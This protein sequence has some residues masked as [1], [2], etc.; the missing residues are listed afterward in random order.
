[1]SLFR[2]N[3]NR[4]D[5]G[6]VVVDFEKSMRSLTKL[7]S[8]DFPPRD[9]K[10]FL[11]GGAWRA[12]VLADVRRLSNEVLTALEC[13]RT[14]GAMNRECRAA[15]AARV[16]KLLQGAADATEKRSTPLNWWDGRV[17]EDAWTQVHEADAALHHLLP[18]DELLPHGWDVLMKAQAT[19]GLDDRRVKNLQR[20]LLPPNVVETPLE[21]D[22][23]AMTKLARSVEH[24]ARGAYREIEEGYTQS[25]GYRNRLIRLTVLAALMV[26]VMGAVVRRGFLPL[27]GGESDMESAILIGAFGALGALI[28]GVPA[29]ARTPGTR[30]PFNLPLHQLLVKLAMGPLFALVGVLFVASGLIGVGSLLDT[31]GV[32]ATAEADAVNFTEIQLAVWSVLFGSAQHVVTRVVDDRVAKLVTTEGTTDDGDSTTSRPGH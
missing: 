3:A 2:R 9:F 11:C 8:D 16:A 22:G 4:H 7:A 24:V 20:A 5:N 29:I 15:Q 30:N 13:G 28:T 23:E 10:K 25:R 21:G 18:E 1:M 26:V 31:G 32:A 6:C 14:T 12:M 27:E 17:R 19:L